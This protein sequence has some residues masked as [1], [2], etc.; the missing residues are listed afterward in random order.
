MSDQIEFK[1]YVLSRHRTALEQLLFFNSCQER[2]A[3]GIADA[4]EMFGTPEIVRAGT[5]R[6]GVT[7]GELHDAQTVFA[8]ETATGRPV[9]VAIYIRPD[10]EHITV[11]HLSIAA[12]Y[13]SGGI[14]AD[15]QLL[16]RLLRELR[17]S[18]RRMKGVRTLE[19]YYVRGR[20]P[21]TRWRAPAKVAM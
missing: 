5:D 17:R 18:T 3:S 1:S 15:E 12:E 6:L 8:L 7:L 19:L 9:G 11:L 10:L 14:R 16:L 13:A 20:S 21:A 4:V 2:V